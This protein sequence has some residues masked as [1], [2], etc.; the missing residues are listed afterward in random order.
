MLSCTSLWLDYVT[1]ARKYIFCKTGSEK[2]DCDSCLL[3]CHPI[4]LEPHAGFILNWWLRYNFDNGPMQISCH[5][6]MVPIIFFKL[7]GSDHFL[8]CN[9]TPRV[10]SCQFSKSG[11]IVKFHCFSL[12]FSRAVMNSRYLFVD[13]YAQLLTNHII[14]PLRQFF[15]VHFNQ[16]SII[17]TPHAD[18]F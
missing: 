8:W 3:S 4:L 7:V 5:T 18:V 13:L 16:K 10:M 1:T 17:H 11:G 6:I 15:E 9:F 14:R 12:S 2:V